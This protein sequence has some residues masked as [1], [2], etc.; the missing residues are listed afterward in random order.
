M[1]V[2]S[3]ER[4]EDADLIR[5]IVTHP[6]VFGF[7]HDDDSP[8]RE[9]WVPAFYPRLSWMLVRHDAVPLGLIIVRE[10]SSYL[11]ELHLGFL[12]EAWGEL[13]LES[14]REFICGVWRVSK[15]Q[16]LF[17]HIAAHNRRALKFAKSAGFR[18]FAVHPRSLMKDGNLV[19][20]IL[21]GLDRPA[22]DR[23]ADD[24]PANDRPA[25][26][27]PSDHPPAQE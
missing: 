4:T 25:D 23:P 1:G 20:Q 22:D 18:E 6:K 24:R 15:C 7:L 27:P 13:A 10:H 9:A 17:G 16:R 8:P 26:D 3:F 12:P 21:V 19:D 14:F 2:I 5:S 11:W